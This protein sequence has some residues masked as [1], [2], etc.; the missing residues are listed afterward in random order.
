[1]K[2]INPGKSLSVNT[3]NSVDLTCL[4]GFLLYIK[5]QPETTLNKKLKADIEK[6]VDC[7]RFIKVNSAYFQYVINNK[8][9]KTIYRNERDQ[10]NGVIR[11]F[12]N[13]SIHIANLNNAEQE[14]ANLNRAVMQFEANIAL[15]QEKN[16][17]LNFANAIEYNQDVGC[18]DARI[19]R[20]TAFAAQ[21]I[22]NQPTDLNTLFQECATEFDFENNFSFINHNNAR[23]FFKPYLGLECRYNHETKIIDQEL[24]TEY[25]VNVLGQEVIEPSQL[26]KT[27]LNFVKKATLQIEKNHPTLFN[28][29][30]YSC[31]M[32]KI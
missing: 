13:T 14:I 31:L 28:I 10:A 5:N 17:L 24:I 19:A 26:Q 16:K 1:M 4:N 3:V 27:Y 8:Q 32:R 22:D 11:D 7:L 15:M 20:A 2:P 9:L 6:V 23:T 21:F 29:V 18:L 12:N 25:L 30:L